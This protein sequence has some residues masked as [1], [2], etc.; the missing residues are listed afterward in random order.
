MTTTTL[1]FNDDIQ[2]VPSFDLTISCQ[3]QNAVSNSL[4]IY[5]ATGVALENQYEIKDINL[6]NIPNPTTLQNY[7]LFKNDEAI[8]RGIKMNQLVQDTKTNDPN[9]M[10]FK[11]GDEESIFLGNVTFS[12]TII[13][14]IS[15]T[16]LIPDN[17]EP[18]EGETHLFTDLSSYAEPV[19]AINLLPVDIGHIFEYVTCPTHDDRVY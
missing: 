9:E 17:T 13:S 7:M 19:Y 18:Y 12:Y 4:S 15:L 3:F 10:K 5:I 2:S 11:D 6:L 8:E 16:D 14:K 1:G